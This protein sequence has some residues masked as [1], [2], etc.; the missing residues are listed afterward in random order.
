MVVFYAIGGKLL[1]TLHIQESAVQ[2]SGGIILL[3]KS[4][5][6]IFP[7]M[8]HIPDNVEDK[9]QPFLV[10]IATPL[11]VGPSALAAIIVYSSQS[12]GFWN[13]TYIGICIAW[14]LSGVILFLASHIHHLL[15]D[16]GV[17]AAE[18]LMGLVLLLLS[19]QMLTEGLRSFTAFMHTLPH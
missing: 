11:L 1:A 19:I 7:N 9:E 4:L 16:K 8:G 3:L 13:D 10:P 6:M 17:N 14:L 18:R 12:T 2:I 5:K 15:G